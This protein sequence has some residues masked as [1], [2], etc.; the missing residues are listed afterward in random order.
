MHSEPVVRTFCYPAMQIEAMNIFNH[1]HILNHGRL[2]FST[3]DGKSPVDSVAAASQHKLV[4][5]GASQ[6]QLEELGRASQLPVWTEIRNRSFRTELG[7]RDYADAVK[8][9]QAALLKGLIIVDFKKSTSLDEDHLIR[10]FG[11]EKT[12]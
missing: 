8:W 4:L 7:F 5:A 12:A 11:E 10:Y 3:L 2:T 6:T 1:V 9:L